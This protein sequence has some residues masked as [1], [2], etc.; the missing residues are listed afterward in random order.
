[1]TVRPP[2]RPQ[3]PVDT[4]TNTKNI[5]NVTNFTNIR[6]LIITAII[7]L[8]L[9]Q[10]IPALADSQPKTQTI[11]TPSTGILLPQPP[12][13]ADTSAA[14]ATRN[15]FAGKFIP[16]VFG[17]FIAGFG[18]VSLIFFLIGG[19]MLLV[20]YGNDDTIKKATKTM[21]YAVIGFVIALLAYSIVVIINNLAGTFPPSA[22]PPAANSGF[23]METAYAQAQP[24][25]T[26]II[27]TEPPT[28]SG[29]EN[30][31]KDPDILGTTGKSIIQLILEMS[32][33][34]FFVAL[35]VSAVMMIVSRGNDEDLKKAKNI[36][37]YSVV[38][39][40][41]IAISYAVFFGIAELNFFSDNTP[42]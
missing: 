1:M 13:S 19:V 27:G 15:Y 10:G 32:G 41:C 11:P 6:T 42:T 22:S 14:A 7:I 9:S 2:I 24:T 29:V 3:S 25:A 28:G 30:L 4:T 35:I 20:S 18:V 38:G 8:A 23:I 34:L 5:M 39:M 12:N 37:I 40:I 21:Q 33:L 26:D 31:L 17:F 36:V 16:H